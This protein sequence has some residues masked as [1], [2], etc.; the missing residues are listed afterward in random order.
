RG[1]V[2]RAAAA[3][4]GGGQATSRQTVVWRDAKVNNKVDTPP[5]EGQLPALGRAGVAS[6]RTGQRCASSFGCGRASARRVGKWLLGGPPPRCYDMGF[7]GLFRFPHP[8]R[9]CRIC[10]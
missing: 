7:V 10:R 3:T 1:Q 8:D 2:S 5:F 9:A 6:A 4:G